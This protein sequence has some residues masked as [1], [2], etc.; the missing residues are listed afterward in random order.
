MTNLENI[1]QIFSVTLPDNI[2]ITLL[3][4]SHT[5]SL[6]QF[7]PMRLAELCFTFFSDKFDDAIVK[8]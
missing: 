8:G 5:L 6:I 2:R 7:T 4:Q 1:E 3:K